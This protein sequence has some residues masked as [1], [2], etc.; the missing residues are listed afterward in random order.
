[1]NEWTIAYIVPIILAAS[2]KP[3]GSQR[4]FTFSDSNFSLELVRGDENFKQK[5]SKYSSV[6]A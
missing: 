5:K 6:L 3:E 4:K 1:M 2:Y